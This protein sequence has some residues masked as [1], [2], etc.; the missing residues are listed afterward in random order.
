MMSPASTASTCLRSIGLDPP[1]LRHVLLLV[2]ARV[3][4]PAVGLQSAGI[5]AQVVQ[6]AVRIGHD[7]EDQAAEGLVGPRLAREPGVLF[8]RIRAF[9]RGH[10]QGAGQVGPH[11]IEHGLHAH[12]VQGRTAEHRH[13][14]VVQ[15]GLAEGLADQ[16]VGHGPFVHEEIHQLVVA[17]R[18]LVE[19]LPAPELG[20]VLHFR[21]DFRD[22][23]LRAFR[24]DKAEH[25]HGDQVDDAAEGVADVGRSLADRQDHGHRLAVQP[26]VDFFQ[27]AV[28]VGPFAVHLVD[29]GDAGDA[30]F[31]GLPPDRL[32]LGLDAL[33][34]AEHHHAAVE[35]A[36]AAFHLGREI[37][38]AGRV[39]EVDRIV[40]PGEGHAGRIDGDA[41]LLLFGV[42]VG[43]GGAF[44]D[45]AQ[46]VR[47]AAVK[48]HPFGDGGLS[49][50]DMGND[51]DIAK[52]LDIVGHGGGNSLTLKELMIESAAAAVNGS[53]YSSRSAVMPDYSRW[54]V[55]PRRGRA[56]PTGIT[57]GAAGCRE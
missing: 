3:E 34:G 42:E 23:D 39:D 19:Q 49:G 48:Q 57:P 31:I 46:A 6:I 56:G 1:E 36:Q 10:I 44:V 12:L 18:E 24:R 28:E 47:K 45:V 43:D 9:H 30:I 40:L 2:L 32:A 51:A 22:D 20:V 52:I 54:G 16:L 8:L 5:D 17:H 35:H 38:M 4:H 55:A 33:P 50:V 26:S 21:G 25:L 15:R 7:L 14:D 53:P 37:D 29:E 11:R 27:R 13:E 41:A